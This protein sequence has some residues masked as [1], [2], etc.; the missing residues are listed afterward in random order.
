MAKQIAAARNITFSQAYIEA[1]VENPHLYRA[2]LEQH[3]R[4]AGGR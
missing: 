3:P 1:M 2:W 4:Q